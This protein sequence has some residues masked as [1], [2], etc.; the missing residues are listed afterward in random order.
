M[1]LKEY[2]ITVY[3]NDADLGFTQRLSPMLLSNF[4]GREKDLLWLLFS[5]FRSQFEFVKQLSEKSPSFVP[6]KIYTNLPLSWTKALIEVIE[7]KTEWRMD[8]HFF[9]EHPSE[10]IQIRK[11]EK[12]SLTDFF[13]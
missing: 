12:V 13:E 1:V 6:F 5:S 2:F 4:E 10:K 9:V 3:H 11:P 7:E 8:Q